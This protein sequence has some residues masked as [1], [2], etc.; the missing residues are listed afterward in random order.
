LYRTAAAARHRAHARAAHAWFRPEVIEA[1]PPADA[2]YGDGSLTTALR[3]SVELAPLPLYL[4]IEDRN[5]MAHSVEAR[6]PFLD[7]RLVSLMFRLP[8]RW[9]MRGP[10][11]KHVMRQA[12]HGLIPEAVRTRVD[13]MGFPTPLAAW[14]RNGLYEPMQDT[15]ASQAVRERGIYNV[16]AIRRDL[17][18]HRR[19]EV[20]AAL[21]LFN[22]AQ[23][24]RWLSLDGSPD[25][26]ASALPDGTPP[27]AAPTPVGAA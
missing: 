6:L 8:A 21:G 26:Q 14:F 19:G 25:P 7:Y 13:K 23:F 27:V 20:D 1:L 12:M 15:L 5:S 3:L 10:N 4:R 18:R 11:T 2:G 9:K 16:D 22:V 24:E 17:E